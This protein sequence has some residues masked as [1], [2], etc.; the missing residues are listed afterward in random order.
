MFS[1][2][3]PVTLL[4]GGL[5]GCSGAASSPDDADADTDVGRT[6]AGPI[7]GAAGEVRPQV[8]ATGTIVNDD[9]PTR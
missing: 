3:I 9:Q 8:V 1:R 7:T 4:L 6:A 2:Q 5:S